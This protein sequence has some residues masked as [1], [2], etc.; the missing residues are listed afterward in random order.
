MA[1][2]GKVHALAIYELLC[3]C[4]PGGGL[5]PAIIDYE[6]AFEKFQARDFQGALALLENESRDHP[7]IVLAERCRQ[8]IAHPPGNDW[9]GVQVFETK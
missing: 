2:K 3:E 4:E 1:V 5:P 6:K 7:S 8:F 9:N